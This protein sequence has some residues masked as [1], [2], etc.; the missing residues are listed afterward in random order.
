MGG[1]G[2]SS[3]EEVGGE[4]GLGWGGRPGLR[5]DGGGQGGITDDL[6]V[7]GIIW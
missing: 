6:G 1:A 2:A 3:R 5:E 4:L 7:A